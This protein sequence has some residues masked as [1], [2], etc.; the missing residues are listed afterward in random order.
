MKTRTILFV[1]IAPM[2]CAFVFQDWIFLLAY[3]LW[4]VFVNLYLKHKRNSN[5]KDYITTK[6]NWGVYFIDVI[7]PTTNKVSHVKFGYGDVENRLQTHRTAVGPMRVR[8][9][10]YCKTR[11]LA[12][13]LEQRI[14]RELERKGC[15]IP[16]DG[17]E[18][19]AIEVCYP[20]T[21][22]YSIID[23]ALKKAGSDIDD[24]TSRISRLLHS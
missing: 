7:D 15:I 18:N 4:A 19:R 12:H 24:G 23:P 2:F 13:Q 1:A 6:S 8:G 9:V 22:T 10:I 11:S 5:L 21:T 3:P 14:K 16:Y 20:S 17:K